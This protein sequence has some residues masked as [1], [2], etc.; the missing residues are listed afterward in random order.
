MK[1]CFNGFSRMLADFVVVVH[2]YIF[3]YLIFRV[4]IFLSFDLC[5][6]VM[7]VSGARCNLIIGLDVCM[8]SLC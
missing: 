5:V 6:S 8:V 2:T 4:N 3:G 1:S 7:I